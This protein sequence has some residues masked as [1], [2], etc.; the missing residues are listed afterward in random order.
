VASDV[1]IVPNERG[2]Y[3][4]TVDGIDVSYVTNECSVHIE[5]TG[6]PIVTLVIRADRVRMNLPKAIVDAVAGDV[7]KEC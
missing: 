5:G 4:I 7:K 3:S 6:R 1:L 2:G